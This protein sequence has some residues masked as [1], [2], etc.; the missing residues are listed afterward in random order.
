MNSINFDTIYVIGGG[1]AMELYI[2]VAA[3]VV[4]TCVFLN[5]ASHKFGVPTLLAFI[6]LGMVFGIDGLLK[7]NFDNYALAELICSLALIFIM[8]YGGFGTNWAS[9]RTVAVKAGVLS[10]LGVAATAGFTAL[11][12]WGV[13]GFDP[14]ESFLTGAVISSTDAA[15]VFSILRYNKLGLKDNVDSL[16]EIESGSNDPSSYMLTVVALALIDASK[17]GNLLVIIVLQYAL[18]ALIGVFT[19]YLAI[20]SLR[21]VKFETEGFDMAFIIGAAMFAFAFATVLGGNGYLSTYIA[22]IIIGNSKIPNKKGLFNFFDGIT[23]LMQMMIFFL[24]GLLSNPS[25]I[26]NIFWHGLAIAIFITF[27]AR[28]VSVFSLLAVFKVDFRQ[29]IVIAFAGLRGAA[30]IVFAIMAV[31]RGELTHDIFHIVFFIVLL[32]ITFQG[33]FLAPLARK[34]GVAD[35]TKDIAKTFS[36]Y[37]EQTNMNFISVN[38]P[39]G[40]RWISLKISELPLPP[41]VLIAIIIRGKKRLMPSGNT[42]ICEGDKIILCAHEYK[43]EKIHLLEQYVDKGSG[44]ADKQIKDVFPNPEELVIMIIRG[45]Q[46]IVPKGNTVIKAD[47]VLVIN[48]MVA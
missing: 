36:D 8:F 3:V 28:P 40:H 22:G 11:F 13:L 48:S 17:N 35:D 10:T 20:Y 18:G 25:S 39:R 31:S 21:R 12:C 45:E 9:G 5:K 42:V 16:L 14:Y 34:L 33:S 46:T 2:L 41:D 32:S 38:I 29:Q 24:L 37:S 6:L 27:V 47:D 30:S 15:S 19:A 43:D 23:G 1:G 4:V 44:L 26:P 7:I